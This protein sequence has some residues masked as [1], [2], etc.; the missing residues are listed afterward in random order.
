MGIGKKKVT[1]N[2]VRPSDYSCFHAAKAGNAVTKA[3]L[4]VWG[5]GNLLHKQIAR[6]V[7]FIAAE[8]PAG[9]LPTI[10]ISY[11]ILLPP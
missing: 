7:A 2:Y 11:L 9:P 10:A 3:S 6:F 4:F 8:I 5:L 1:P